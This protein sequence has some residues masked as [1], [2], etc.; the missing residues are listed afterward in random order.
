M[1]I[2][3]T[4]SGAGAGAQASKDD[5]GNGKGKGKVKVAS[6]LLAS[7]LALDEMLAKIGTLYE[8]K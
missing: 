7:Q 1:A 2:I 3:G 5:V 4:D 8:S 6:N